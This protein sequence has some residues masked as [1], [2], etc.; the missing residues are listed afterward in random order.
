[1]GGG[2]ANSC[3]LAQLSAWCEN[4]FGSHMMASDSVERKFDAP[5]IVMDSKLA[6]QTWNWQVQTPL[7]VLFEEIAAHALKNPGWLELS[8]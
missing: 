5:W 7:P 3:S 1:V 8:N 2:L 6:R 4:R